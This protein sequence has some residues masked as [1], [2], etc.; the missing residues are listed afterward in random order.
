MLQ[1]GRQL[2]T[3]RDNPEKPIQAGDLYQTIHALR[4]GAAGAPGDL[5]MGG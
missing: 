2:D 4:A 1:Q 5:R 3:L